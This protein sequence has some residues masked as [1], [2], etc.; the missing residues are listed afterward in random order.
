MRINYY[1][2]KL[3]SGFAID[4]MNASFHICVSFALWLSTDQ[5]ASISIQNSLKHKYT[6]TGAH[7]RLYT[8]SL[9]KIA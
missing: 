6:H 3:A 5:H 7:A 1:G 9:R 8:K 4:V 2:N